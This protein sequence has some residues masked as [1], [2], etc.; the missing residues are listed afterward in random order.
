[1][2]TKNTINFGVLLIKFRVYWILINIYN[3]NNIDNA[4]GTGD[5]IGNPNMDN[6]INRRLTPT[7][8]ALIINQT[9]IQ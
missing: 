6:T 7:I 5:W 2:Y 4:P 8:N 9:I 3:N 1:M